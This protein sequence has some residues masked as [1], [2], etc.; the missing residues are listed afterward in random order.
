MFLRVGSGV[1]VTGAGINLFRELNRDFERLADIFDTMRL[2]PTSGQL[3]IAVIPSIATRLLIPGIQEFKLVHPGIS[4]SIS[5]ATAGH[6]VDLTD[7]DVLID[8][9]D[10]T[11]EGPYSVT[12]LLS[13]EVKP[14]CSPAYLKTAAGPDGIL[15]FS[16]AT[17][18][19]DE[20]RR[21]WSRWAQ[22]AGLRT[23]EIDDGIIF[24]D[25]NLLSIAAIAGHGVALCPVSLISAELAR[26]D[27]V[28][29]S[30]IPENT[31]RNYLLFSKR[32]KNDAVEQFRSWMVGLTAIR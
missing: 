17:L 1:K 13:G 8:Y 19:H 27:L 11:Y 14:V 7:T 3:R 23:G 2:K 15:D 24:A 29:L 21:C 18:L 20:D 9:Y 31:D 10:G 6:D 26:G 32:G 12:H 22:R 30:D 28:L 25:F 16:C 5:Y 4:L